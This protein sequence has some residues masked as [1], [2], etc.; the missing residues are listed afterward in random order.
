[1][2]KLTLSRILLGV[3]LVL[4][5]A[6][7]GDEDAPLPP[8][9]PRPAKVMA[10]TEGSGIR[11]LR[12]PLV[13]EALEKSDLAFQV[14]GQLQEV[15]LTEGQE[16][17][18]GDRIAQ[19]DQRDFRSAVDSA[20]ASYDNSVISFRRAEELIK[21]GNIAQSVFDERQANVRIARA[22]LNVAKKS[23]GDSTLHAPFDGVIA[24]V[25]VESFQ[26]IAPQ[27][28]VVTLQS[29]GQM[30][31]V[32]QLPASLSVDSDRIE[33]ISANISLDVRPDLKID[34]TF[35]EVAQRSD[36]GTQ[37]FEA[38]FTFTP[39]ATLNI[40][41]GMT[42]F[43]EARLRILGDPRNAIGLEVPVNAI[44]GEG[45]ATYVF[46]FDPQTK[47]VIKREITVASGSVNERLR[48]SEGLTAGEQIVVSGA[49][50]LI[51]GME[52]VPM[53]TGGSAQ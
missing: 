19:L 53:T 26:S 40:L 41:P 10:V 5:A 42:G 46:V 51:D 20:Q 31:A 6:G 18:K 33:P 16:I 30:E 44:I 38:R 29:T 24:E 4:F 43:L 1:M 35:R 9:S 47:K 39:P 50:Y 27:Q 34:T 28:R 12:L 21:N 37:T 2:R 3:P 17:K 48:V 8:P 23:L 32:V 13:V 36:P 52:I 11:S 14:G 7:C 45:D 25:H 49:K 22:N 15:T